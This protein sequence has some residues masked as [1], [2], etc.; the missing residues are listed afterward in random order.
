MVHQHYKDD[1]CVGSNQFLAL[2]F[3]GDMGRSKRQKMHAQTESH[4]EPEE[5]ADVWLQGPFAIHWDTVRHIHWE[6]RTFNGHRKLC[7]VVEVRGLEFQWRTVNNVRELCKKNV[8][9]RWLAHDPQD[10]VAQ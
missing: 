5:P 4:Q 6:W 9:R 10:E 7:K 3:V 1:I 8:F 2:A